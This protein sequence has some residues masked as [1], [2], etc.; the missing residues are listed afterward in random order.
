MCCVLCFVLV[1]FI[2]FGQQSEQT[3]FKHDIMN[4]H[5]QGY[6]IC[7]AKNSYSSKVKLDNW[8]EDNI[9]SV[10]AQNTSSVAHNYD[11]VQSSCHIHPREM[12]VSRRPPINMPSTQELKAKN[13]EGM[14]YSM[15]FDHGLRDQLPGERFTTTSMLTIMKPTPQFQNAYEKKTLQRAKSKQMLSDINLSYVKTTEQRMA[16]AHLNFSPKDTTPSLVKPANAC[17]LPN[18]HR[19]RPLTSTFPE[20]NQ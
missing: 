4:K 1:F 20:F 11:T 12:P 14:P 5:N 16:N 2:Y 8:V 6:G 9:G 19:H 17:E 7:G 18:F 10:L 3:V 13:K 15:L